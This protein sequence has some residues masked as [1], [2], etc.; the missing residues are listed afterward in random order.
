[1]FGPDS[2]RRLAKCSPVEI[3]GIVELRTRAELLRARTAA[4]MSQLQLSMQLEVS[5]S[6]VEDWERGASRVPAWA[7]EATRLLAAQRKAV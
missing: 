5:R 1:M 6:A 7:L 2:I 4:G 3:R